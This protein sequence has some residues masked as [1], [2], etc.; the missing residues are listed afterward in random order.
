MA[1]GR[2]NLE[3]EVQSILGCID[4][5]H[6][7][8]LSGGAGSGKTYSMVQLIRQ[9]INEHSLA[10]IACI[11]YTNAAVKEIEDRII[12]PN[13]VVSTIHDFLW[14]TIKSFQKEIKIAVIDLANSGDKKFAIENET[15]LS[16]D[17]F[18]LL[19]AGIQ[20]KEYSRLREGIISHDQVISVANYL[21]KEYLKICDVT[22]DR[23]PFIFV[24][25]YQDTS[26]QVIEILLDHLKKSEK[27][28]IVGFFG[29]SMQAIYDDGIGNLDNY[30]GELPESIREIKKSQNRRNPSQIIDLANRLRTDGITQ[31]P[32]D[33][34]N[35]PNMI[36]GTVKRGNIQFFYSENGDLSSVKKYLADNGGWDFSNPMKTKELNLT[37]N[38]IAGKAGFK[39]LMSIYDADPIIGLK[40]DILKKIKDNKKNGKP[41]IVIDPND[42][43]ETV[44]DK[45]KLMNRSKELKKDVILR[46]PIN[47]ALFNRLRNELFGDVVKIYLNK[48][49]LV[50][51]KKQF[52]DDSARR[53]SKRDSLIK[54]LFKIQNT[55]HLYLN[56]KY[57]EFL[58]ITDYRDRLISI[59]DKIALKL[60][61][62][63]LTNVGEKTI[64]A[65]IE[66]AH[67]L[68]ICVKDDQFNFFTQKNRYLYDRVKEVPFRDFQHLYEYLE[69]RTPFSTQHKTKG[70]EFSDVLVVLDNGN[71]ND[72]NFTYLFLETGTQSVLDRTRKIFY[73]CC[74]RAKDNLAV[75]FHDPSTEIK[76]KAATWFG[77]ENVVKI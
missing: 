11:T 4:N 44:V 43:F 72:Y 56:K 71:W 31:R 29:D 40:N 51:D 49:S 5:G 20:Y 2:L 28:N 22:K 59:D 33:D 62:E 66:E 16:E 7:F 39:T 8:L 47:L 74:T 21:F 54:H 25:E 57:N 34:N 58:K 36:H 24:D 42:S 18:D 55:V 75:F 69:G 68:G 1:Q 32:S 64:E 9:I 13:L 14:D 15:L 19:P 52:E 27:K 10:S 65:V 63:A 23:Y 3:P 70:S 12:H 60:N 76:N 77:Q 30:K 67:S 38:L 48:D 35:A 53:G 6:N 46:D 37:H 26:P 41:E 73:V 45:F 50:D 61:I 17:F